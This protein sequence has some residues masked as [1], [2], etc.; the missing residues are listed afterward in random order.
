VLSE[1]YVRFQVL[2]LHLLEI[3]IVLVILRHPR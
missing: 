1:R 3:G 2:R